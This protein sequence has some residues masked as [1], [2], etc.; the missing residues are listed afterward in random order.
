VSGAASGVRVSG[1]LRARELFIG[2]VEDVAL[3]A[4]FT[5]SEG[6][7]TFENA[8][9]RKGASIVSLDASLTPGG[10]HDAAGKSPGAA[11]EARS[12]KCS[13]R[14]ADTPLWRLIGDAAIECSFTGKGSLREPAFTLY[15]GIKGAKVKGLP[16]ADGSVKVS[17][18]KGGG[19]LSGTLYGGMVS[20]TGHMDNA[21]DKDNPWRLDAVFKEGRYDFL[22]GGIVKQTPEDLRLT[23]AGEAHLSGTNH[24]VNGGMIM[25]VVTMTAYDYTF[26]NTAPVDVAIHDKTL[27]FNSLSMKG[28]MGEFSATGDV[29]P[30]GGYNLTLKG[31][32]QMKPLKGFSEKISR[33]S[34]NADFLVKISGIWEKPEVRGNL[35]IRDA[36]LG[37]RNFR[38]FLTNIDASILF[39]K[40]RVVVSRF[41]SKIG[42]GSVTAT[43]AANFDNFRLRKF[44]F[45]TTL[46]NVPVTFENGLKA[47]FGGSVLY[48][49]DIENRLIAGDIRIVRAE[50]RKNLSWRDV[51]FDKKPVEKQTAEL[52]PFGATELNVS[53]SGD[54]DIVIDNNVV[55]TDIKADLLIRGALGA[56]LVFG[57]I[58]TERGKFYFR[59]NDF[60]ITNASVDFTGQQKLDPYFTVSS[61][62]T[63]KGYDVRLNLNGQL[64]RFNMYLT[65]SPHLDESDILSLLA[66]GKTGSA[67]TGLESGIG[68]QEAASFLA[69]KYKDVV[70]D[71]LKN[72]TGLDRIQV[73][74]QVSGSNSQVNPQVTISKRLLADNLYVTLSSTIGDAKQEVMKVEYLFN[75]N[76]SLVGERDELGSVGGD[77]KFRFEFK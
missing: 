60:R 22:L 4:P 37:I 8:T 54:K 64:S 58:E 20:I 77:I 13:L 68:T 73:A 41:N 45:D 46:K 56:P 57:R 47:V 63:V 23:L 62:S 42:S 5:Y 28:D 61:E 55:K 35:D 21:P 69:G 31:R 12:K 3:D 59:N 25:P 19:D 40:D 14:A 76:V 66:V 18:A 43:G 32:P 72:L 1:T 49:G 7:W 15:A 24:T 65:S 30:G 34:G 9:L 51:M 75:K 2:G 16:A 6:R 10:G 71:R 27:V 29:T 50:F 36:T 39:D 38:Y 11:F 74:P 70:E 48:K 33:I 52:G 53:V 44:Y 26:S 67:L 17:V